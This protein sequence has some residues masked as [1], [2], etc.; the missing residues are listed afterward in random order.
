MRRDA[1][2]GRRYC[3]SRYRPL[4]R[5]HLR[6]THARLRQQRIEH[7]HTE[8]DPRELRSGNAGERW[9]RRCRERPSRQLVIGVGLG[10]RN[11][12]VPSA[13][14]LS[15]A[16]RRHWQSDRATEPWATHGTLMLS[17]VG[18]HFLCHASAEF[19]LGAL[20]VVM[21]LQIHPGS[22]VGAKEAREPQRQFSGDGSLAVHPS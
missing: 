4:V 6:Q 15:T 19:D 10:R 12:A 7:P 1:P 21:R 13:S 11:R 22:G 2:R 9:R 18:G 17:R 5:G 20:Q 14:R 16:L 3:F 8:V